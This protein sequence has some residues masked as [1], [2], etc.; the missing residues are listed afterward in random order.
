MQTDISFTRK[1][2]G[3]HTARLWPASLCL[4][5]WQSAA[6][7]HTRATQQESKR[8][9]RRGRLI[10]SLPWRCASLRD[11]PLLRRQVQANRK[12]LLHQ[13]SA[14]Q[15]AGFPSPE[16]RGQSRFAEGCPRRCAAKF[17]PLRLLSSPGTVSRALSLQAGSLDEGKDAHKQL[18]EQWSWEGAAAGRCSRPSGPLIPSRSNLR[19]AGVLLGDMKSLD[20]IAFPRRR[21]VA[22]AAVLSPYSELLLDAL[23]RPGGAMGFQEPPGRISF[24]QNISPQISLC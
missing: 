21:R 18:L 13:P 15:L 16:S 14:V 22:G 9:D 12:A 1:L 24:M 10:A 5:G 20:L 7:S 3:R 11:F 23:Q 4:P 8:L 2:L 6:L 17:F 19:A